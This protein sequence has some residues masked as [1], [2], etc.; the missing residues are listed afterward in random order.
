MAADG[1]G[2]SDRRGAGAFRAIGEVAE[3]LDVPK[4]VLRF[5]EQKFPQLRPMKR[6]GGR[7]YYRPDDVRL[8]FGIRQLLHAEGFQIKGVQKIFKDR[9]VDAV[10][11]L[12]AEAEAD[13]AAGRTAKLKTG[14]SKA[15]VAPDLL[16]SRIEAAQA[17]PM[18]RDAVEHA[19]AE[20]ELCRDMLKAGLADRA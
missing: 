11:A 9:G 4:H 17:P 12:G 7:R 5:W 3:A 13:I 16:A 14:R 20:L 2:S 10:K 8:L 15:A 6:G 1:R 19:I 18:M